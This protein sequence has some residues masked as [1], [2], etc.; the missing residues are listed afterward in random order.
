M[1]R[2]LK[3]RE[4]YQEVY[5]EICNTHEDYMEFADYYAGYTYAYDRVSSRKIKELEP[6]A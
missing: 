2:M 3:A 6:N 1:D 5:S 4:Y